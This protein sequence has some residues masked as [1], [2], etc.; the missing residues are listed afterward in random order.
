MTIIEMSLFAASFL[1]GFVDSISGGGGLLLMPALLFAGLPPQTALGTNKFANTIGTS[2]ALVNFMRSRK[3]VWRI[4]SIG[5][6]FSLLGAFL[7]S[8][9]ILIFPNETVGKIIVI[10]LPLAVLGVFVPKIK[11]VGSFDDLPPRTLY[12]RIIP[13]CFVIGF[14]DGF[15]GPGTGSFLI[16]AFYAFVGLDLLQASAT[17]KVFNLASNIGALI[18]FIIDGK[19]AFLLGFPLALANI[20]GNYVGSTLAIRGGS[21]VVKAFLLVSFFILFISLFW[22]YYIA[23]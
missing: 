15:F 14:Y 8:K 9:A 17:A 3:V 2:F 13:I 10:L 18:V 5:I 16:I 20:A 23:G 7:G 1:A 21:K 19:V 12:S 22:K 11:R 6:S 4:A